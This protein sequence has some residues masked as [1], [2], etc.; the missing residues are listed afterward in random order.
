MPAYDL[1]VVYRPP[2]PGCYV[3]GAIH[4][5]F[6]VTISPAL[7]MGLGRKPL[8]IEHAHGDHQPCTLGAALGG[9]LGHLGVNRPSYI[10]PYEVGRREPERRIGGTNCTSAIR[11]SATSRGSTAS[12]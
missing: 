9:D 10:Q 11:A 4:F 8:R 12:G 5:G 6:D 3:E 7:P 2:G 1:L